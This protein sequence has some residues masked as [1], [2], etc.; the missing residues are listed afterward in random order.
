M[1]LSSSFLDTDIHFGSWEHINSLST[2]IFQNVKKSGTKILHVD[3]DILCSYTNFHKKRTFFM[4]YIKKINLFINILLLT[5]HIMSFL[6]MP[7]KIFFVVKNLCAN[8]ECPDLHE[9]FIFKFFCYLK[10]VFMHFL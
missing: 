6:P 3:F 5:G 4:S 1:Y 8:I 7:H 9:K 2:N 10:F